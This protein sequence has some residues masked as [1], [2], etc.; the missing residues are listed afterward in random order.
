MEVQIRDQMQ[1]AMRNLMSTVFSNQNMSDA[2]LDWLRR[3][4]VEL[5]ERI[6]A[7]TPSRSD[8]HHALEASFDVDLIVQMVRHRAFDRA[9]FSKAT[10]VILERLS[11]LC[12]PVQD[13]A[14]ETLKLLVKSDECDVGRFL[15]ESNAI[16]DEIESL[17]HQYS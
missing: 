7:L 5:K 12:A 14:V 16:I 8:L 2:D 13:Q 9:E 17:M 3:L 6:N 1:T 15:L 11:M 4:C 10:G